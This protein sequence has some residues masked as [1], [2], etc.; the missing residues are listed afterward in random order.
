M[1]ILAKKWIKERIIKNYSPLNIKIF[2][3]WM[4]IWMKKTLI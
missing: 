1:I 3:R 4:E 2:D